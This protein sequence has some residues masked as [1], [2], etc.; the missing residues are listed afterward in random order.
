MQLRVDHRY[1]DRLTEAVS[2]HPASLLIVAEDG[3]FGCPAG[4]RGSGGAQNMIGYNL[5]HSKTASRPHSS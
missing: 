2:L 3:P 1:G 5:K 4:E